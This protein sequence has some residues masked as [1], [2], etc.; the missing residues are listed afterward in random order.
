MPPIQLCAG[1]LLELTADLLLTLLYIDGLAQNC[2]KY[3]AL[4]MEYK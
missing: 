1:L 3:H 4:A 2:S